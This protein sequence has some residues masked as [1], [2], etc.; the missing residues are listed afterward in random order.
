MDIYI[1]GTK[2]TSEAINLFLSKGVSLSARESSL[3][4][5]FVFS[6]SMS[7]PYPALST[8]NI[9]SSVLAVPSTPMELVNKLT[10]TDSTPSTEATA[11]STLAEQA[12]QVIPVTLYFVISFTYLSITLLNIVIISSIFSLPS[13]CSTASKTQ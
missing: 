9:I 4:L 11:F 12:A 10:D 2:K 3:L 6:P 7:A 8:A 1:R 5:A 13:P